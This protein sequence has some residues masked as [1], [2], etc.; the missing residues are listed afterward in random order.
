MTAGHPLFAVGAGW[1]TAG[2]VAPGDAIRD[3]GL[4]A[5]TVIAAELDP[6]PTRVHNLEVAGAHTYFAGELEA[7]GHNARRYP[8]KL[9]GGGR[10]QP[11]DPDT[12]RYLSHC[13]QPSATNNPITHFGAGVAFG[14]SD[15][16]KNPPR[17][18]PRSPL[19]SKSGIIGYACSYTGGAAL[20][21]KGFFLD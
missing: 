12:G 20:R 1:V 5:L 4:R 19:R 13:A 10:Q 2:E 21:L 16:S 9:G 7:W 17:W 3:A 8:T 14:Y 18:P 6:T 15:A 11:Y